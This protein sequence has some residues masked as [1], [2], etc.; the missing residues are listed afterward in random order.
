MLHPFTPILELYPLK[1]PFTPNLAR[2]PE[3]RQSLA[4]FGEC[5]AQLRHLP[6]LDCVGYGYSYPILS[7]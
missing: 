6:S 2:F 5:M 4:Q 3:L 1:H 7:A